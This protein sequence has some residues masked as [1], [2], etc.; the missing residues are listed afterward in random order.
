MCVCVCIKLSLY[1]SWLTLQN[2]VEFAQMVSVC[3]Q[4]LHTHSTFYLWIMRCAFLY[5]WNKW[6]IS[7]TWN[8]NVESVQTRTKP[9]SVLCNRLP[10]SSGLL[11]SGYWWVAVQDSRQVVVL[12]ALTKARFLRDRKHEISELETGPVPSSFDDNNVRIPQQGTI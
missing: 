11:T 6:R 1:D 4:R 2:L 8:E 10:I 5:H 7:N 3:Q 12:Q 9:G